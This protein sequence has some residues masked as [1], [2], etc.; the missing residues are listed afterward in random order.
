MSVPSVNTGIVP[1]PRI[2]SA[3]EGQA[4]SQ[5]GSS[6]PSEGTSTAYESLSDSLSKSCSSY[7]SYQDLLEEDRVPVVGAA[8]VEPPNLE[9]LKADFKAFFETKE[10]RKWC[11]QYAWEASTTWLSTGEGMAVYDILAALTVITAAVAATVL[12][13]PAILPAG[14]VVLAISFPFLYI[15]AKKSLAYLCALTSSKE[16]AKFG[17]I[18]SKVYYELYGQCQIHERCGQL[19]RDQKARDKSFFNSLNKLKAASRREESADVERLKGELYTLYQETRVDNIPPLNRV[20]LGKR[21]YCLALSSGTPGEFVELRFFCGESL[22]K[23]LP[24]SKSLR[25]C[26]D[27]QDLIFRV[28]A[29]SRSDTFF[30]SKATDRERAFKSALDGLSF[31]ELSAKY[32]LESKN[33]KECANLMQTF[34]GER[35]IFEHLRARCRLGLL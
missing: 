14:L 24:E 35:E 15:Y 12:A 20:A 11:A 16:A 22:L 21:E 25:C 27:Q 6:A 19:L 9:G 32:A 18:D 29:D 31:K 13:L 1:P 8:G 17:N 5:L 7:S 34:V 33:A 4:G 3:S 10:G 30:R 28:N 23:K 2:R 26:G